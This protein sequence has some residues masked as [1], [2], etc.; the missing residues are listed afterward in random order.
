MWEFEEGKILLKFKEYCLSK[1]EVE[2][3]EIKESYE[4]LMKECL[5]EYELEKDIMIKEINGLRCL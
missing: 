2:L 4:K 3:V 1:V 5:N